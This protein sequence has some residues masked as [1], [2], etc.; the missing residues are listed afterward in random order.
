MRPL[1]PALLQC[2]RSELYGSPGGAVGAVE[3]PPPKKK[4]RKSKGQAAAADEDVP[5]GELVLLKGRG[6]GVGLKVL[7]GGEQ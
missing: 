4:A 6:E 1:A 3:G 2:A 5:I 7:L